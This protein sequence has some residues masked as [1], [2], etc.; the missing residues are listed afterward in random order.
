MEIAP[1][2]L[3]FVGTQIAP[4]THRT[5]VAVQVG[6]HPGVHTPVTGR[7]T[8]PDVVIST[9]GVHEG[10]I[11][12]D[13]I[14]HSHDVIGTPSR[15]L[16]VA[17]PRHPV[18][19]GRVSGVDDDAVGVAVHDGVGQGDGAARIAAITAGDVQAAALTGAVAGD[20]GVQQL[21]S[22]GPDEDPAPVIGLGHPGDPVAATRLLIKVVSLRFKTNPPP[23]SAALL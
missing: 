11:A 3:E 7:R 18:E 13:G 6:G 23:R 19:N 10:R 20:G 21:R 22:R 9:I 2:R 17:T 8:C 5:G 16:V 1:L 12:A 4:G 15:L 14:G